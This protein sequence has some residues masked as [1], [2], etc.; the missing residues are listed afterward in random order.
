MERREAGSWVQDPTQTFT[1]SEDV[2]ALLDVGGSSTNN[3]IEIEPQG[4][5]LSMDAPALIR[6]AN[7]HGD[8]AAVSFVRTGRLR[9]RTTS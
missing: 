2:Q 8:T 4:T 9:V 6:F 3:D 7:A 1:W 5:V